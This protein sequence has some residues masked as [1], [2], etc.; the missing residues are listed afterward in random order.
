MQTHPRNSPQRTATDD[1]LGPVGFLHPGDAWEQ[2]T[3]T[4]QVVKDSGE[5]GAKMEQYQRAGLPP[6][7]TDH[8]HLPID[9]LGT[10]IGHIRLGAAQMPEHLVIRPPFPRR[11]F[12]SC[13]GTNNTDFSRLSSWLAGW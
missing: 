2:K 7:K 5:D 3:L 4:G 10:Q 13:G 6:V 9:V 8:L 1:S 11:K 12:H